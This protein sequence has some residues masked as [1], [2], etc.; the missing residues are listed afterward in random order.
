M[1]DL[2]QLKLPTKCLAAVFQSAQLPMELRQFELSELGEHEAWVRI[3]CCTLCGS[4]LHTIN[5]ARREKCPSILGHEVIGHIL[6][7]GTPPLHDMNGKA[8]QIGDRVTW[9]VSVSCG[10]CDRCQ[11]GWP[12]KCRTLGKYGHELATGR[13]AL[14]GG[15]AEYILLRSGSTVARIDPAISRHT[16]CPANCATATVAAAL[17]RSGT[18]ANKRVLILGAGM[19][20]LTAAAMAS[21]SSAA[22]VIMVDP[23][24]QRLDRASH[25]GAS[26]TVQWISDLEKLRGSLTDACGYETFDVILELSGS[27]ASVRAA[28]ELADIGANVVLVG[29]VMPSPTVSFDPERV[30]RRCISI[31]GVHNYS[32][33]DLLVAIEF[34]TNFATDFPF[35][36]LIEREFSLSDVNEAIQY[37]VEH[38]PFRI[39]VCP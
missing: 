39:A 27:A 6:A 37:A 13:A 4:D 12:Q 24:V 20:G 3:E 8:L 2:S 21:T 16:I 26:A 10:A 29:T 36:E 7:L 38:R 1:T 30:V 15:L 23:V 28:Y 5:G 35:A 34:L 33:T 22:A 18:I 11:T 19:L 9:S 31:H 32:P 17:R 14:S 25:F